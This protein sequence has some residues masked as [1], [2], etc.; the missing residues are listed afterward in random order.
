VASFQRPDPGITAVELF[1][2]W[3]PQAF[4][5]AG[6]KAPPDAPEVRITLSGTGGGEWTV[7]A[8]GTTLSVIATSAGRKP[9]GRDPDVW[10]RQP[11]ADFLAAFAQDADLPE[12][13]P[14]GWGPL[15]LLFLDPRDVGLIRQISGRLL[16]E[17]QGKRRRRW[18]LDIAVGK[19]GLA[20]GRPRATVRLDGATYD[21]LRRGTMPPLQALLER[22]I[23][24][25]GD[26]ALAMQ[27]LVL[28]G[29]RLG[30]G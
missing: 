22:K 11:T 1:E 21:G 15:D 6:C 4:V 27:A 23:T 25:E 16:V 8:Q 18:G 24:V 30:R 28:L 3:L 20:A 19:A 5:A 12:L 29:S 14:D 10:L 13:L 17:I 2:S 26:R 7:S 9:G